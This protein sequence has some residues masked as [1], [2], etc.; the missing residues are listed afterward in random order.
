[1][2]TRD[3][4]AKAARLQQQVE[5]ARYGTYFGAKLG[6][7]PDC[8]YVAPE[9]PHPVDQDKGLQKKVGQKP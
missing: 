7:G 2:L 9:S 6:A 5:G 3:Q 8:A 1:M 4:I